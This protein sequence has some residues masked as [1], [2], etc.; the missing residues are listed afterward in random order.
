MKTITELTDLKGKSVLVRVDWNVPVV[1]RDVTDD[2]RIKHS[3]KTIEYLRNAGAKVTLI[4]HFTGDSNSL[5]SIAEYTKRYLPELVF[6]AE[7]D[8]V[9]LENLRH[10]EGEKA[11]DLAYA[12]IL[13]H[14]GEIF[15][16]EAFSA[17]HR[18]HASIISV[19]KFIPGYAG[20]RFAEEVKELSKVFY[21]KHPF[22]FILGGA[23]SETKL[24]LLRKFIDIADDV[25]VGGALAND[26][27]KVMGRDVGES[28]VSEKI[29]PGLKELFN[30]GKIMLPEDSIKVEKK[31]LD[32][33]PL[34]LDKLKE[35]ISAS[36]LILW[37]GPL[38]NYETGYKIGTLTLARAIAE[39]GV[40]SIIGGGDTLAAIEEL[41]LLNRF[42]F[43]STGGGA[44]LD[45]LANGT[46]PGIEALK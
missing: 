1:G 8:L 37:N 7:G 23:K 21:P 17:S 43:V 44:M 18:N 28:L 3:L 41:G 34:A 46:L 42:S 22:L 20:L 14:L 32:A 12:E 11:N 5:S 4:S 6:N 45:F 13:S 16:N 15:V 26:F 9:L 31:I 35:K 25:F 38:G 29:D 27:F 30:S 36:K 19:P 33:G 39:S 40:E 24:P 10:D 2:F